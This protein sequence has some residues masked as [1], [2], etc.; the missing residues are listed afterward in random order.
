MKNGGNIFSK[1]NIKAVA[2]WVGIIAGAYLAIVAIAIYISPSANRNPA[3][4]AT[5]RAI[6][7]P[8]AVVGGRVITFDRMLDLSDSVKRFYESQDFSSV[9]LRVDF[10]SADGQKRLKIKEKNVFTKLI[11]NL[12]IE[13]EAKDAGIKLTDEMVRQE[14]ER[15]IREL[16]S[17]ENLKSTLKKLYGWEIHDFEK[18]VVK[19]DLYRARLFEQIKKNDSS[20]ETARK[21][22]EEAKNEME[23]DSFAKVAEK[24]SDGESAKFGGELGW[25][26]ADQMLPDVA[27][28]AFN[29]EKG[30]TS[31]II[32]SPIGYH[33]IEVTDKKTEKE[34]A[35][36]KVRQIFV[37]TKAFSDWLSEREKDTSIIT[38]VPGY[39]WS[40]DKSQ[41]EFKDEELRKFEEEL[42]N[43]SYYDASI[44]F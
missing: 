32:E 6:P 23:K 44:L 30:K 19:P 12:I 43:N 22:I 25:F 9:G 20:Y 36:V 28:A 27:L 42:V 26:S 8:A 2:V 3:I 38:L 5:L 41:I 31:G 39:R 24:Y 29:L 13:S 34:I 11:E 40:D 10:G 16:G 18:N 33:I 7:Y 21:K 4:R 37:R 1:D 15:K 35:L 14:L 17:D